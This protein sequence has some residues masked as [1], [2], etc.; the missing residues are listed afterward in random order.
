MGGGVRGSGK[1]EDQHARHPLQSSE[2]G[3]TKNCC[4]DKAEWALRL[5]PKSVW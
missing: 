5:S 4:E 1:D 3:V 2:N